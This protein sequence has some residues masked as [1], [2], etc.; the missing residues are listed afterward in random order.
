MREFLSVDRFANKVRLLRDTFK[1]TFL[2]VEGSSDKTFYE[3]FIDKLACQVVIISGKP[4][5]K[6]CVINTLEILDKSNFQGVLAIVDAD[7]DRLKSLF[8]SSP[9]LLYT[10]THDLEIMLIQSPALDKVLAEFGSDEK[11]CPV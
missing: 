9:N 7:F 1:G 8:L 2:L 4:S 10:D 11:N 6:Q 5:S 3:R